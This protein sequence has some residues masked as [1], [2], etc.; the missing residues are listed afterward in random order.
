M[1]CVSDTCANLGIPFP[2]QGVEV[3][4]IC[5]FSSVEVAIVVIFDDFFE[6][7]PYSPRGIKACPPAVPHS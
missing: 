2:E 6:L 4:G 5:S 7:T 3:R 1:R